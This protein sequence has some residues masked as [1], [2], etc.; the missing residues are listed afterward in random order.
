MSYDFLFKIIFVGD[1]NVGKSA[2][3]ERISRNSFPLHHDPT[4]GVDFSTTCLHVDNKLIKTH[5]WDTAGQECFS[6][7]ISSY[8][9]GVAGAVIIFDVC[10]QSSFKKCRYW[11]NQIL[12]N[13]TRENIPVMFLIGNKCDR[14]NRVI[15][16][17]KAEKFAKEN[18]LV[19][20]ETSA[21]RDE[22]IHEFYKKLIE[23]IYAN[24]DLENLSEENG[25]RKGMIA[26]LETPNETDRECNILS[27]CSI[28]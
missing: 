15:S 2:I 17:E 5:I 18:N 20:F 7:I 14:K 19:Y 4:I 16:S 10:R 26:R 8:Y 1:T 28:V 11:I 12:Q 27:C 24:A 25:I 23:T 13:N 22:N 21:K 6:S 9:R 3:A